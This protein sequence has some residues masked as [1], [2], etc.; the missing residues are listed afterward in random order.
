M[1]STNQQKLL[2]LQY[3][4]KLLPL[5]VKKTDKILSKI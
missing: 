5:I 4:I 3:N 2:E 1:D